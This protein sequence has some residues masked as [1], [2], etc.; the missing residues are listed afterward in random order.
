M[1]GSRRLYS[2]FVGK[3][4]DTASVLSATLHGKGNNFCL[5]TKSQKCF[6]H[7]IYTLSS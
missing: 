5:T 1:K 4:Y 6:D 3:N 2:N 7:V